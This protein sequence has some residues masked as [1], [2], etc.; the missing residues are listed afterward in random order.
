MFFSGAAIPGA[1]GAQEANGGGPGAWLYGYSGPRAIGLGGAF[2]AVA[3]EP[4]GAVWN[5]A[6]LA[7]M[8]QNEFRVE[9]VRLFEDTSINSLSFTVP[10]SRLPTFGVSVLALRSG[11]FERTNELNDPLGSFKTGDTAFLF[12]LSKNLNPR[13]ALGGNFKLAR[14]SVEEWSGTGLGF[15]LGAVFAV[16][17]DVRVGTSILNFGGPTVTLRETGES[18]PIEWRG[19][20]AVKMLNGRGLVSAEL[21]ANGDSGT[22]FHGGAE[23]WLQSSFALRVGYN[24]SRAAGGLSYLFQPGLQ[25]D[26]GV[27]DHELGFSHRVGLSYRFGGFFASSRAVPEVFSPTGER[28]I[29]KIHLQSRTKAEADEWSLAIVNKSD[30][31]VRRYSGRGVPPAHLV[32]D[33]KDG[34]GLPLPDGVY[35][36]RLLVRDRDGRYLTSPNQ[37]V[38]ISTGGPQGE[39]QVLPS[40]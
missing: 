40:D 18:F 33:G 17:P 13:L 32:W 12:T 31:T 34:T 11:E 27:T 23:Y 1:A 3:D 35:H 10:G 8:S 9:T 16:T 22:R 6:G 2:V 24:D 29:T 15:D 21:D 25:L 14:Q 37:A 36:Y 5:P 20:V 19:G 26:Y 28:P 4:M 39:I 7:L 30:E 38:E